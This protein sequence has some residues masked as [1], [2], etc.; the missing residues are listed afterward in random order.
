MRSHQQQRL[1]NGPELREYAAMRS[2]L[3]LEFLN[4]VSWL[5]IALATRNHTTTLFAESYTGIKL[6]SGLLHHLG[7]RIGVIYFTNISRTTGRSLNLGYPPLV[8]VCELLLQLDTDGSRG[9]PSA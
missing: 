2:Q 5:A 6:T 1:W 3:L 7:S 4:V 8:S 9:P